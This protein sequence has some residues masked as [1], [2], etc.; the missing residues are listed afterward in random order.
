M[1]IA[2]TL[3]TR[4]KAV[5]DVTD[6]IGEDTAAR[7]FTQYQ[8]QGSALPHV[9]IETFSGNSYEHL[10]GITGVAENRVQITC[11]GETETAAASLA[12]L[13][14]RSL[15]GYRGTVGSQFI[16]GITSPDGFESGDDRP[17]ANG[18]NTYRFW[19]RRDYE[20]AYQESATQL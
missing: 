3:K 14:R 1:S 12:D 13:V 16:N 19:V 20:V 18:G 11:Y 4:L 5:S 10:S 17:S 6:L 8:P 2:D 9:V 15:Q 7:V